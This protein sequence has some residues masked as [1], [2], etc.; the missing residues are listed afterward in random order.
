[1]RELLER[2]P[3]V[4]EAAVAWGEMDSMGHVNNIVYFR[5]FESARIA[6]FERAGFMSHMGETGVGPI[7][8]STQCRFRLPL[9]YPDTVSV[10]ARVSE[11]GH[12]RFVMKYLVVSHRHARPAAEGEGLV[13]AFDYRG[14]RKAPLPEEI[15]AR[16][17]ALEEPSSNINAPH[18][19]ASA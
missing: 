17:Q 13:V 18:P 11:M 2:Y 19:Q 3:V 1:M 10:G 14:Q 15:K 4:I 12:D 16:I 6:Y 8:A 5:Y 7:L 9:A